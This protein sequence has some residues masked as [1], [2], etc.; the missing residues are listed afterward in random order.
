MPERRIPPEAVGVAVLA[1]HNVA[2][3]RLLPAP[4]DAA[5]NLATAAGLTSPRSPAV[6][7]P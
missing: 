1:L 4:A 5:L 7:S 3:H 6:P 2:V